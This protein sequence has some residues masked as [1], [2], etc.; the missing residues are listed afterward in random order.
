MISS[1][2]AAFVTRLPSVAPES[3]AATLLNALL[4]GALAHAVWTDVRTRRISN[5]LTYP[6]MLAGL[7]I[8]GV[9]VGRVG[10]GVSVAGLVVGGAVLLIPC[11]LGVM[12]L[13]DL[14]LLAAIGALKGPFF[15]LDTV[16]YG[17]LAG[18]V[19]ALLYLLRDTRLVSRLGQWPMA[20]N[21]ATAGT[22]GAVTL[23]RASM[24]YAP[25]IAAGALYALSSYVLR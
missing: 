23:R 7:V 5:R 19:L 22:A 10:L 15:A 14:K 8:N 13:G 20:T 24:P 16:L 3:A 4:I 25:A 18:G 6:L 2:L 1:F 12:G 9:A 17:G 21:S 11:A